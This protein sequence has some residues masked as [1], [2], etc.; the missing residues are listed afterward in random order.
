MSR[1]K[2]LGKLAMDMYKHIPHREQAFTKDPRR[3]PRVI[4]LA[5]PKEDIPRQVRTSLSWNKP[6]TTRFVGKYTFGQG[7]KQV[8]LH[9]EYKR[10][11]EK[12]VYIAEMR[13][14][15]TTKI[16][17]ATE[18]NKLYSRRRGLAGHTRVK[19]LL[20]SIAKQFPEAEYIV[21]EPKLLGTRPP[22]KSSLK[23]RGL[24]FS[25]KH[26]TKREKRTPGSDSALH[27]A[28]VK[29]NVFDVKRLLG[30]SKKSKYRGKV[31]EFQPSE[32]VAGSRGS[33]HEILLFP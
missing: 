20:T 30:K 31:R 22:S 2:K 5:S 21:M 16:T 25:K 15:P 7:R 8:R 9:G 1:L 23:S 19:G 26:S 18:Y 32:R 11:P 4:D 17:S 27:S 14:E 12:H 28:I 10:T 6:S 33:T 3:T 13:A 29:S 24:P